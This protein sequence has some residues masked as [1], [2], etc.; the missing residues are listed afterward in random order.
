MGEP[1][2]TM[3]QLEQDWRLA[4]E[5]GDRLI[6]TIR[7]KHDNDPDLLANLIDVP[8]ILIGN[9][10]A[11]RVATVIHENGKT[12]HVGWNDLKQPPPTR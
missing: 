9:N 3:G 7:R 2:T 11:R 10:S 6:A 4:L 8:V 12:Y 5:T 1:D